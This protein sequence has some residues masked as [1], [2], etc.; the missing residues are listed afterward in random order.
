M[1]VKPHWLYA[2]FYPISQINI[3]IFINIH[4][5]DCVLLQ[6]MSKFIFLVYFS[7][8]LLFSDFFILRARLS[9]RLFKLDQ[10]CWFLVNFIIFLINVIC[11]LQDFISTGRCG[12]SRILEPFSWRG[13]FIGC[14]LRN[15]TFAFAPGSNSYHYNVF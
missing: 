4:N 9:R 1:S 7:G 14:R 2:H 10:F 13:N 11:N 8:S 6:M 3:F 15:F 5:G 12:L